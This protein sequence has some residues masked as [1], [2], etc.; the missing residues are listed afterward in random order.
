[1]TNKNFISG[2]HSEKS[3]EAQTLVSSAANQLNLK[4]ENVSLLN[5]INMTDEDKRKPLSAIKL[6]SI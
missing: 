1:M 6:G 3:V 5:F 2:E 4:G